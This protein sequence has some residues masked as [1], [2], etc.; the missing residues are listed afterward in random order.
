MTV[1]SAEVGEHGFDHVDDVYTAFKAANP[2]FKFDEC[3]MVDS[4]A[5]LM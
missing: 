1:F 2:D 3:E 5:G 4:G